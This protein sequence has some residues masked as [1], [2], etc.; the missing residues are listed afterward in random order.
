MNLALLIKTK[1]KMN[2]FNL[3]KKK[4]IKTLY[5]LLFLSQCTYQLLILETSIFQPK[6][7]SDPNIS[8]I[9][10]DGSSD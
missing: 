9:R 7:F 8:P 2:D 10:N 3:K 5:T 1:Q 4:R 6:H